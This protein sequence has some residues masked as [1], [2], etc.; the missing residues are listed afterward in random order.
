MLH[1]AEP[2]SWEALLEEYFF[3]HILRPDTEWSYRKV[4]RGF[5]RFMGEAVSPAQIT[6][7]DVLRWRRHLLV[8]KKQSS[9]TWNNK[10]AHLRAIFNFGMAQKL[11]PHT[12]NPFNHA[13]VKK[14]KKKKKILSQ[15]QITRI[16]LLMGKF[17]EEERTD[18]MPRGGRCALYPTW[19]WSTVLAT[20]RFTGMR[21]NQLL[22]LR[23]RDINLESNY[24]ELGLEGSK[25]HSEWEI[26][27]IPQ[28]KP[29]LA[30]LV[31]RAMAAGAE[32]HDPIFDLSRLSVPHP[33]R[34]SRYQ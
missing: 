30:Q 21:Q 24:I 5:I 26:P 12:E 4:T 10:V 6:H 34:L 32:G 2:L 29:W 33:S 28:L 8:E 18:V 7:R 20:L 14:E 19:Y 11:L 31:A 3:S 13:V 16:N 9:H 25:N 15:P 17:A 1:T 23:L 22:H 27:I